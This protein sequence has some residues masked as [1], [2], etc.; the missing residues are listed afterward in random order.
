M[1]RRYK[2]K[3]ENKIKLKKFLKIKDKDD[4]PKR[5]NTSRVS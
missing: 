1:K 5:Y 4:R 2:V 3:K